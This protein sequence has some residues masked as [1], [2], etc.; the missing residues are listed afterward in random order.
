M[1][2]RLWARLPV[3]LRRRI[4]RI[5]MPSYTLGSICVI[6]HEGAVLL[7][8]L[9]Y[10]R[11]WGLPGGLL[12]RGEGPAAAAVRETAEEVGIPVEILGRPTIVVDPEARRG[13]IVFRA[14]PAAGVDSAD[15][16][17]TSPEIV[18]ARWFP[19]DGLPPLHHEAAGA[20]RAIG[21][22]PPGS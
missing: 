7:V 22:V 20:L 4:V 11:A 13:D 2:Y 21:L 14:R 19:L 9:S 12:E 6:E 1:K 10:R 5:G 18:E 17:S 3:W 16:R 15:V 8:R